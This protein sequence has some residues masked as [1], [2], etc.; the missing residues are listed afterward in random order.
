MPVTMTVALQKPWHASTRLD[1]VR[2]GAAGHGNGA[3]Q[4]IFCALL[5]FV[6][7]QVCNH[8]DLFEGRPIV[9]AFDTPPLA[10]RY[11]TR[12]L[13]GTL[14]PPLDL[15]CDLYLGDGIAGATLD[16][17]TAGASGRGVGGGVPPL[18]SV[19]RGLLITSP[20]AL[21]VK[22]SWEA[23]EVARLQVGW[24][25]MAAEI[26]GNP[27]PPMLPPVDPNAPPGVAAAAALL[28]A[29]GPASAE[30]PMLLMRSAA[31][32]RAALAPDGEEGSGAGPGPSSQA[33]QRAFRWAT[34]VWAYGLP[35]VLKVVKLLWPLVSIWHA[36][37]DTP[38]SRDAP[39]CICATQLHVC[40]LT[41]HARA[42]SQPVSPGRPPRGL[43]RVAPAAVC[44]AQRSAL[45]P[46]AAPVRRGPDRPAQ[47]WVVAWLE[48]VC[49]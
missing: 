32:A 1:W 39:P 29:V 25:A 27:Q 15:A 3:H 24:A 21:G 45:Q 17:D 7:L 47:G 31:V 22:S 26:S 14:P 2:L 13:L 42:G 8:P 23:D 16:A 35:V 37:P 19:A 6:L 11:P 9:S 44:R 10:L 38:D 12:V 28:A 48:V 33:M 4:G 5:T 20:P 40:S 36:A 30:D 34:L 18:L 49:L 46:G 41:G 43:A